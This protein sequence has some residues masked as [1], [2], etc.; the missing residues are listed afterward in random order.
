MAVM[1]DEKQLGKQIIKFHR[2][3][4]TNLSFMRLKAFKIM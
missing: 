3:L 1:G 4:I 2:I